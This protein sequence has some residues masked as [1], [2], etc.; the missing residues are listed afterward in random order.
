M[1]FG[2]AA[3]L[4]ERREAPGPGSRRLEARRHVHAAL[5]ALAFDSVGEVL[6]GKG[7]VR[8]VVDDVDEVLHSRRGPA[9]RL[10]LHYGAQL[11]CQLIGKRIDE[12]IAR[13]EPL[14]ANPV[15]GGDAVCGLRDVAVQRQVDEDGGPSLRGPRRFGS[16]A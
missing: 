6:E 5:A 11:V 9:T 14:D 8:R 2:E 15:R 10:R 13:L 3:L 7:D 12:V 1:L 4:G 16:A